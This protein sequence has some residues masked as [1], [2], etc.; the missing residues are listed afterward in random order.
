MRRK[1]SSGPQLVFALIL[2]LLMGLVFTITAPIALAQTA[3]PASDLDSEM[4]AIRRLIFEDNRGAPALER[5]APIEQST[6]PGSLLAGRVLYLKA[7]ALL[8]LSRFEDAR[9]T[10]VQA[11]AVLTQNLPS[12]HPE[13]ASVFND[14]ARA[15]RSVGRNADAEEAFRQAMDIRLRIF[16][17]DHPQTA[18]TIAG[19]G[20]LSQAMGNLDEAETLLRRSTAIRQRLLP[21]G[22]PDIVNALH[23]LSRLLR[24]RGKLA[25]AKAM[26]LES[27]RMREAAPKP[28]YIEIAR[29]IENYARNVM[30]EGDLAEAATL[31]QRHW[32]CVRRIFR[33]IIRTLRGASTNL[34]RCSSSKAFMPRPSRR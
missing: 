1:G 14:L 7:T 13:I 19:L 33:P 31:N 11:K 32:H 29:G 10:Y 26:A 16:G 6:L 30:Q 3:A 25:E 34:G 5:L 12:D 17:E 18:Q 15:A 28:D 20:L 21:A 23:N 8:T 27:L 9:Q 22:H 4:A 24:H 2:T